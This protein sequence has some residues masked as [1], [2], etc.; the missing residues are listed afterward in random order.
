MPDLAFDTRLQR[1]PDLEIH[2]SADGSTHIFSEAGTV[3][4]GKH[5][6]AIL[7]AFYRDRSIG[8]VLDALV[9][10]GAPASE[11]AS[12]LESIEQLYRSGILRDA[13]SMGPFLRAG[14][15]NYDSAPIHVYML[16]DRLRVESF[17]Q[18]IREVVKPGDVVI[19]WA[20]APAF[21]RLPPRKLARATFMPS[22]PVA[23]GGWRARHSPRTAWP[24]VLH[25]C[26][27]GDH[28]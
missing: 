5:A 15:A 4:G 9:P 23:L 28:K 20:Q 27:A 19:D 10:P 7:G 22:K 3:A 16:N 17:L 11:R 8:A 25:L 12:I 2:R 1:I 24:T 14:N 18:G 26:M 6:L 13:A 21:L